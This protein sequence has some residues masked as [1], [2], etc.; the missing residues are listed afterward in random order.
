MRRR[1]GGRVS[2]RL[3]VLFAVTA[4]L[5]SA[6]AYADIT[7]VYDDLGRLVGVI[8]PSSD[9]ATYSYDAVGNLLSIG[10]HASS[11]ASVIDFQ[12][13]SGPVG[14]VVT[15]QGTGFSPTPG[16]NAVTLNGA[17]AIVTSS[18]ATSLVVPVPAGATTGSIGATTPAGSATSAGPFTVTATNGAPVIT[19]FA[20]AVGS[21]GAVVTITGMNF[22]ATPTDNKVSFYGVPP[23][24]APVTTHGAE[25]ILSDGRRS[26]KGVRMIMPSPTGLAAGM[27]LD[28]WSYEMAGMS[29]A[30]GR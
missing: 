22:E 12:P 13:K 16:S 6:L 7:Y 27:R 17:A 10:R 25:V 18:I 21:P 28:L 29:T 30:R 9:T 14:T 2:T 20:P 15:I 1:A 11:S 24:K 19:S 8:D 26:P 3:I 4:L 23:A 5:N